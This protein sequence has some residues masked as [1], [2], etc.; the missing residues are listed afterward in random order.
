MADR[1]R[2]RYTFKGI[3]EYDGLNEVLRQIIQQDTGA[4]FW[5]ETPSM[6]PMGF[7]PPLSTEGVDRLKSLEGVNVEKLPQ[8]D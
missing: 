5:L 4:D 1:V 8:D 7:P 6:P 2:I 3:D